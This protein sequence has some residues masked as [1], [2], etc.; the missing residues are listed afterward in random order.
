MQPLQRSACNAESA[1]LLAWN[2]TLIAA[3]RGQSQHASD[4][5]YRAQ[6]SLN[7]LSSPQAAKDKTGETWDA[8]RDSFL[9]NWASTHRSWD[10]AM[11]SAWERWQVGTAGAG[12]AVKQMPGG[13]KV[14][15]CA[16]H[17]YAGVLGWSSFV[18]TCCAACR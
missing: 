12:M 9:A 2:K 7:L 5:N 11:S 10:D 13:R 15:M 17:A 3:A 14:S 6:N 16:Q 18:G 1:Q 4:C 8:A